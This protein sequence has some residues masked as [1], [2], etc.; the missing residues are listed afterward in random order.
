MTKE[1]RF[2][3]FSEIIG[4]ERAVHFLKQAAAREKMPH[5]YLFVGIHGVG[6]TTTAMALTQALNC[7]EPQE[8]EGCG[9]CRS[10]R[11][12]IGGNFP[13]M[14]VVNPDGRFIRIEQIRELNRSFSFKPVS[15]KYRVIILRQAEWMTEEAANAFLKSLEEPP[16][17]NILI[18]NVTEPRD[19]LPTIVSRCQKVSFRPIP[20]PVIEQW[21]KERTDLDE[22]KIS[23]LAGLCEGSLGKAREMGHETFFEQR[24]RMISQILALPGLSPLELIETAL[25]YPKKG[26][27]KVAG[28][29][30]K[31]DEGL[32][33]LL[34]IWK[35]CY[36]DMLLIKT[37]SEAAPL[38]NIDFA[39]KLKKLSE[40]YTMPSL[41]QCI[42]LLDR[43]QRDLPRGRN[44]DLLMENTVLALSGNMG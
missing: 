43:V 44:L 9:R 28:E 30:E 32:I 38:M 11:Q 8:G 35:S 36:R 14:A 1:N 25:D 22:M 16:E 2:V 39:E 31:G 13:D 37:E 19:L 29:P 27:A 26:R 41:I 20:P 7:H 24:N 33:E 34:S 4:Q 17:G 23:V 42:L 10:C 18:L 6:K 21:L 5:A 12:I 40:N 3:P 15:G